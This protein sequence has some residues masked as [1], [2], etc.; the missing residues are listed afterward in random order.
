MLNK[1]NMKTSKSGVQS[2]ILI[3]EGQDAM[4]YSIRGDHY[5]LNNWVENDIRECI[6]DLAPYDHCI[7]YQ[8]K[9]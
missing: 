4:F 1:P 3:L 8:R 9:L 5:H 6:W 7:G 2:P